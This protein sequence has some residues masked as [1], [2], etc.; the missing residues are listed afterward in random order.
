[1]SELCTSGLPRD[2]ISVRLSETSPMGT[3]PNTTRPRKDKVRLTMTDF[4][5]FPDS[6]PPAYPAPPATAPPASPAPTQAGDTASDGLVQVTAEEWD[7]RAKVAR[8]GAADLREAAATLVWAV[9]DNYFGK[10]AEG[11]SVYSKLSGEI[12]AWRQEIEKQ[13][14]EL[15]E[16]AMQCDRAAHQYATADTSNAEA[17]GK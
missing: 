17:F 4:F 9:Q 12:R 10:C 13:A 5:A 14:V 8:A 7:Y 1:M 6:Y 11:D 2:R 3:A 16:L 15:D